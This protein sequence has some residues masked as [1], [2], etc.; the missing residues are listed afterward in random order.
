MIFFQRI[1]QIVGVSFSYNYKG[2]ALRVNFKPHAAEFVER[3]SIS[4]DDTQAGSVAVHFAMG[5]LGRFPSGVA[6]EKCPS[7]CGQHCQNKLA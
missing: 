4:F 7:C 5:Q 1:P 6:D 2:N 3:W